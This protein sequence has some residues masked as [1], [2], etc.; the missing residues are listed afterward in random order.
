MGPGH[1]LV[2]ADR[3]PGRAIRPRGRSG[4]AR[5]PLAGGTVP[6]PFQPGSGSGSAKNVVAGPIRLTVH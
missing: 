5:W 1:K 4:H 6:V 2:R 3:F